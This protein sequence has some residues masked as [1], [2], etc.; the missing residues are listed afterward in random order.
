ML[1]TIDVK[2]NDGMYTIYLKKG[3][4]KELNSLITCSNK[5]VIVSDTGVPSVYKNCLLEQFPKAKLIEFVQGEAQKNMDTLSDLL[6]QFVEC[7]LNRND[8]VVALGGGV[9]GDLAGFAASIYMR[10]IKFINIPTTLLAQVD[11]SIGGKTAIDF[12]GYKN[13]VG[14]FYQPSMVIIDPL[15]LDTLPKRQ[16]HNGLVEAIKCGMIEDIQL[17]ELI[18]NQSIDQSQSME[19]II[20]RS[21]LVKKKIVEEDEK[22]AGI[23]KVLNFGHTIGHALELSS[24]GAL[25]H[26]EAVGIGMLEMIDDEALQM[27]LKHVLDAYLLPSAYMVDQEEYKNALLHD[28]K[29][30]DD[31][32][33]VVRL[34]ELGKP[35]F[36]LVKVGDLSE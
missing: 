16:L 30:N 19:E 27:R 21:L 6:E 18:E 5:M 25:L 34:K 22:E 12:M 29:G 8:V 14:S 20:E 7:G 33:V 17:F 24:D 9:V 3:I 4:I 35:Y 28:K 10:G 2:T 1:K 31:G 15:V 36:T 13:L 11:S 32:I 26:G 23:R